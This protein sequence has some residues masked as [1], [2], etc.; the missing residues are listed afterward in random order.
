MLQEHL[1]LCLVR[2]FT[3]V[4]FPFMRF[5]P[6]KKQSKLILPATPVNNTFAAGQLYLPKTQML[7]RMG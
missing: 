7:L 6:F 5:Y 3:D 4:P 2:V 1:L